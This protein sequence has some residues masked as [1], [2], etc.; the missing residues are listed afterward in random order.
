LPGRSPR[1]CGSPPQEIMTGC[2]CTVSN[3]RRYNPPQGRLLCAFP[4]FFSSRSWHQPASRRST[5]NRAQV[6]Y[7]HLLRPLP[8]SPA[9]RQN[10]S[11]SCP[12][13]TNPGWMA[14]G[15]SGFR[16]P[17]PSPCQSSASRARPATSSRPSTSLA[18]RPSRTRSNSPEFRPASQPRS[19][20]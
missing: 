2:T 19:F 4:A 7:G 5:R 6:K 10:F 20:K 15:S 14:A 18:L 13:R 3:P 12:E 8:I 1:F 16:L 17:R 11:C 9:T